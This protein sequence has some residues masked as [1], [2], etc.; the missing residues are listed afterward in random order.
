[1]DRLVVLDEGTII[2]E[3]THGLLVARH[4]LYAQLWTHQSGGF[5]A[6][7]VA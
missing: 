4:G 1:M 5:L 7:N 3:G 6:E 2:E